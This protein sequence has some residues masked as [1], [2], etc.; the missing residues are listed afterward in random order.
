M[1]P[2]INKFNFLCASL[3]DINLGKNTLGHPTNLLKY[4]L[5]YRRQTLNCNNATGVLCAEN[6]SECNYSVKRHLA[7]FI[8][9]PKLQV[10][11]NSQQ[12]IWSS[13]TETKNLNSKN[14][15]TNE[16][17]KLSHFLKYPRHKPSVV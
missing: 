6:V 13:P 17:V 7:I 8:A 1:H 15:Y 16:C 10:V 9:T 3:K 14:L 11:T 2:T 4:S 5:D 12:P